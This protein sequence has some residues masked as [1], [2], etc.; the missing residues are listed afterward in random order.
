MSAFNFPSSPTNG[1]TY[2]LNS[3]T[4][5]YDGTKWIRFSASVGA[6]GNTGSTGAQ[7]AQGTQGHQGLQGAQAHI[8]TSAPSSGVNN[9]DL[10]W[11][12]DGGD[13]S[14]YYND[15]NSSQWVDI[16]TGPRG[17]QG[18]TGPTGAQGA[19]GSGGSTG[20]QGAQGHQGVTGSTGSQGATAAQGAQG[21][22][23]STG[24]QGATGAT[25]AQGATGSTGSQGAAGSA[26]I[27]NNSDNRIITGGSGSNLVGET[28]LTFDGSNTL[29]ITGPEGGASRIDLIC[30][31]GDDAADKVRLVHTSGN[32][33]KIQRTTSHTDSLIINSTGLTTLQNF[34]GAGL[35]LQG[36]G[37]DYQGMQ[38]QVTDASA[39]QTRNVFID[40]VNETG[41]AVAN[42]I[43]QIQSDGGSHWHWSTQPPGN[44]SDRRVERLRIT[45][46]G[47]VLIGTTATGYYSNNL[48]LAAG[49]GGGMTIAASSTSDTNFINFADAAN[50]GGYLRGGISYK[51]STDELNFRANDSVRLR[52]DSSGRIL[53]GNTTG[54]SM[55]AAADNLVVGSGVGH[56]GITIFSA[57]DA[58]GWLIFNDAANSNLTGSIQYNHVDNYMEF[59]T[60]TSQSLRITSGGKVNIGGQYT[61][62][63][64]T[65]SANSSNGSCIIIGNTSGTGSGSHDAQLVASHGS[66]FDNLKLTGHQ[67][68]VFANVSGGL[69]LSETWRFNSSGNLQCM[70]SGKGIDFSAT[71]DS[72]GT[73]D[74]ELLDDYEEGSFTASYS[75]PSGSITTFSSRGEYVKIGRVVHFM[76]SCSANGSNNPSGQVVIT[77]LPFTAEIP[78]ASGPRGGGGVVFAGYHAP[79][80]LSTCQVA[81]TTINLRLNNNT[82]LQANTS[83]T[84]FGYNAYQISGFGSYMTTA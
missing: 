16:N 59:R 54:G 40:A 79:P 8:S 51:H 66:D 12:S 35:K 63:V 30:D 14:I 24:A 62:T 41:A 57:A 33:F 73:V 5:K 15:G 68:K 72:S 67:V 69:G 36:S 25:G 39:S 61:Q 21:A 42:Q 81:G 55:N 64:H 76:F 13:L 2:T 22:T 1:D 9:G 74:A 29:A 3:V 83:G 50:S 75:V 4:Y 20:A 38:L 65:L 17:A 56:N 78:N 34:N 71:A 48:V 32:E 10:W 37:S 45:S 47:N 43:G 46:N 80:E 6:Q 19:T 44:R 84:G 27:S 70:I 18:A 53:I 82:Y 11:D 28:N 77:G 60:N 26:T 49:N 23:G 52:I 58:D 31:E 7:G